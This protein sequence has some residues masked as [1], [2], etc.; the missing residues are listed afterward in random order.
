ML[1]TTF[2]NTDWVHLPGGNLLN[3]HHQGQS[4]GRPLGTSLV[5]LQ[6]PG[7]CPETL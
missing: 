2:H 7:G 6:A 5:V 4:L 3:Q 1:Q